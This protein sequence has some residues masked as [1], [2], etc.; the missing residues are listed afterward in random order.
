V[1]NIHTNAPTHKLITAQL[2]SLLLF[3]FSLLKNDHASVDEMH[4]SNCF[5]N[6]SIAVPHQQ[7]EQPAFGA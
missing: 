1:T 7:Q 2:L 3:V 4:P 6:E 5:S